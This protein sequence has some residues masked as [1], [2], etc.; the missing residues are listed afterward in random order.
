MHGRVKRFATTGVTPLPAL[1][2]FAQLL[3]AAM[4]ARAGRFHEPR[5]WR[6]RLPTA[7]LALGLDRA[8]GVVPAIAP[9]CSCISMPFMFSSRLW[10]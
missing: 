6:C 10:I 1:V 2:D 3:S 5:D 8:S 4:A 9:A 7:N